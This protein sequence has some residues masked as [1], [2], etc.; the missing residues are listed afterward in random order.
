MCGW[1]VNV[2]SNFRHMTFIF[3]LE[4]KTAL[5]MLGSAEEC[6]DFFSETQSIAPLKKC[7]TNSIGGGTLKPIMM[8]EH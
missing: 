6:T 4:L 7:Q 3:V 5:R 8:A 2:V 1:S